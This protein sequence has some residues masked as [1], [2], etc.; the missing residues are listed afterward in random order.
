VSAGRITFGRSP[1]AA[2]MRR[3]LLLFSRESGVMTQSLVV[4]AFL[5][6]YPFVGARGGPGDGIP[7]L[8]LSPVTVLFAAFFGGQVGSRMLALERLAFWRNLVLPLGRQLALASKLA[9]GLMFTTAVTLAIGLIHYAFQ[10][11]SDIG[12]VFMTVL[13]SW[14]GFAVGL[15]AGAYWGNFKWDHPK[16]ML[17]GSG[18]FVYAFLMMV[19]GLGSYGLTYLSYRYLSALANPVALVAVLSLGILSISYIASALRLANM[20]WTP[21]V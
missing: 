11:P 5:L 20:E 17:K 1:L 19:V 12:S 10:A 6:L 2:H 21:E 13:F 3:D 8:G 18:G 9:V 7:G 14:I 15:V 16:R 4:A